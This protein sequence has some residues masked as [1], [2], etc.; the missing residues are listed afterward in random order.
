[1]GWESFIGG[2]LSAGAIIIILSSWL[3]KVWANRILEKDKAKYKIQVDTLLQDLRTENSKE[4]FVHRLQFEKE[5]EIYKELWVA[6]LELEKAIIPLTNDVSFSS[7]S[8]EETHSEI[9]KAFKKL[10]EIIF[11]NRPFYSSEIFEETYKITG[12]CQKICKCDRRDERIENRPNTYKN[13]RLW[14]VNTDELHSA[15]KEIKKAVNILCDLI[16]QRIWST[17]KSGWDRNKKC[18]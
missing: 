4:L 6:V 2:G 15:A 7:I 13:E 18:K 1:M 3:G 16:R 17:N 9:R 10:N 11:I 12:L 14:Q 8:K 5:F